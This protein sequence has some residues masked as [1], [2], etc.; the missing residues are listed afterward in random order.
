MGYE[1]SR[2][3]SERMSVFSFLHVWPLTHLEVWFK[4]YIAQTRREELRV[5]LTCSLPVGHGQWEDNTDTST[6]EGRVERDISSFCR[7]VHKVRNA[8]GRV[9]YSSLP[10]LLPL[11]PSSLSLPSPPFSHPSPL[12]QVVPSTK[13]KNTIVMETLFLAHICND[14]ICTLQ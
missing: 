10:P 12:H 6:G 14:V 3:I 7:N 1:S 2:T 4:G 9:C 5:R 13:G 8:E 11:L